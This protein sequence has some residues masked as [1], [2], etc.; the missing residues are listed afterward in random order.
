MKIGA[1]ILARSNFGRWPGK[2]KADLGGK[3]VIE[4]VVERWVKVKGLDSIILSTTDRPED[5]WL[6]NLAGRYGIDYTT[7]PPDD[8]GLRYFEA[9][10]DNLLDYFIP[11]PGNWPFIEIEV[12]Q[13][14]IQAARQNPGFSWY[15]YMRHS[16]SGIS[17]GVMNSKMIV[18]YQKN[19]TDQEL[20]WDVVAEDKK[21]FILHNWKD[22][23]LR[24][25]YLI[26]LNIA[27]PLEVALFNKIIKYLGYYPECYADFVKAYTE[28]KT[29]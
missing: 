24:N 15:R 7:G 5:K 25:K 6:M 18:E 14:V 22:V 2:L 20:W 17:I 12:I 27:Y 19:G 8:R 10:R 21:A 13:E 16:C 28:M 11:A 4:R 23:D 29:L 1:V 26:D 3:P 9:V